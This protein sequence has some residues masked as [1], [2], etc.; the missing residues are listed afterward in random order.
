MIVDQIQACFILDEDGATVGSIHMD[1]EADARDI[2]TMVAMSTG[3]HAYRLVHDEK[4][5]G[6]SWYRDASKTVAALLMQAVAAADEIDSCGTR[7]I[8]AAADVLCG[9]EQDI[10][11]RLRADGFKILR[12]NSCKSATL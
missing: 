2:I 7:I 10:L 4:L 3:Y 6:L 8:D 5:A 9:R 1:Y 11:G 12:I